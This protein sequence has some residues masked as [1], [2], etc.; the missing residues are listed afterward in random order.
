MSEEICF[1]QRASQKR[2][3]SLCLGSVG[4]RVHVIPLFPWSSRELEFLCKIQR[5]REC[6]AFARAG[7]VGTGVRNSSLRLQR[8]D[9]DNSL[10]FFEFRFVR[11]AGHVDGNGDHGRK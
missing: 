4:R 11:H 2:G 9:D 8:D 6:E 5:L 7:V 3:L 10:G 1:F